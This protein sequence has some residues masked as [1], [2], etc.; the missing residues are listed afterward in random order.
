MKYTPLLFGSLMLLGCA[1][2]AAPTA[3]HSVVQDKIAGNSRARWPVVKGVPVPPWKSYEQLTEEERKVIR[4]QYEDM[5][6]SDEPPYPISG[7]KNIY[8]MVYEARVMFPALGLLYLLVDVDST[9]KPVAVEVVE[10]PNHRLAEY[11]KA[12]LSKE[13]FK[14][15]VCGGKP[16]R[17]QFPLRVDLSR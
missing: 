14:P 10:T 11:L 9:G 3:G 16:C 13:Q 17:M 7:P 6:S 4:S 1:Q 8:L 12:E 2:E 5:P 15:A